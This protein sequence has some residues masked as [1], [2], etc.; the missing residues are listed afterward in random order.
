M[1]HY[2]FDSQ[3]LIGYIKGADKQNSDPECTPYVFKL[4]KEPTY[5]G[6]ASTSAVIEKSGPISLC[7]V[8]LIRVINFN[9]FYS[10]YR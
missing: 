5:K 10:Y 6:Q 9:T 4:Y 1:E 3:G 7:D 2:N 8:K